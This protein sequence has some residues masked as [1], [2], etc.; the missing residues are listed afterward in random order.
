MANRGEIIKHVVLPPTTAL[1]PLPVALVA[2]RGRDGKNNIITVAWT[3]IVCSTPPMLSISVRPGRFSHELL[4]ENGDFVVNVPAASSV[5][6]ADLCG[7]TS[8]REHDKFEESHWTPMDASQVNAP[9]IKE[10][11]LALECRTR[12]KISLGSHDVFIAE[13]VAVQVH[14]EMLDANGRLRVDAVSP[15]AYCPNVKGAGQYWSLKE[16]IGH[17]GLSTEEHKIV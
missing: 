11:P 2:C 6:H 12:Q 1:M 8:G 15:L 5:L 13:I 16:A 4:S 14:D 7:T 9:I 17:Y 10:C 3:G